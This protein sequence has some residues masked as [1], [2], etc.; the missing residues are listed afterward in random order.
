MFNSLISKKNDV[1]NAFAS[2]DVQLKK[3]YDLIPNI[4]NSV[5]TYMNHEKETLE[6]LTNIR[7]KALN[8]DTDQDERI[9]IENQITKGLGQIMVAVENYPDLKSS[10][11]FDQLQRTLNEVESQLS[12]SRRSFNSAV[13]SFNNALEMFPTNLMAS[14]MNLSKKDLFTIPEFERQNPNVKNLFNS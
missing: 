11:N 9:N 5:Q 14:M 13:T 3:R 8:P 10:S 4:I 2:I 12:A 7:A 1:K 6:N